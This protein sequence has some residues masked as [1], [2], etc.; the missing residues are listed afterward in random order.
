MRETTQF[1]V[2][3]G[4]PGENG[5]EE[6]PRTNVLR[7]IISDFILHHLVGDNKQSFF[8]RVSPELP[9]LGWPLRYPVHFEV[10]RPVQN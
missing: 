5:G 7:R 1:R 4:S 8:E 10:G 3:I 9:I 6:K 2:Q